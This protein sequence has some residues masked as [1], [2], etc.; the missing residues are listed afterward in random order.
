MSK[1]ADQAA[2]FLKQEPLER[3]LG[4]M[5]E[6][7][8][9]RVRFRGEIIDTS[10]GCLRGYDVA[11]QISF[12][13]SAGELTAPCRAFWKHGQMEQ[14]NPC[15]FLLLGPSRAIKSRRGEERGSGHSALIVS[16]DLSA[17]SQDPKIKCFSEGDN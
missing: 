12:T 11:P 14:A 1:L 5:G 3:V 6:I 7:G 4:K 8:R 15:T 9:G 2:N 17:T 10:H 16:R 13:L